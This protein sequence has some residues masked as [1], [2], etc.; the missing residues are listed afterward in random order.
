M[1]KNGEKENCPS[2][3]YFEE[4][5]SYFLFGTGQRRCVCVRSELIMLFFVKPLKH[6]FEI[7]TKQISIWT[8]WSAIKMHYCWTVNW[9]PT[10]MV[11]S[12]FLL[13]VLRRFVLNFFCFQWVWFLFTI[14]TICIYRIP[15][16]P[17]QFTLVATFISSAIWFKLQQ[18]IRR[19][20]E[21]PF[22]FI[23]GAS[24]RALHYR[25]SKY[26]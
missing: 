23:D 11:D 15:F 24:S 18:N 17:Y 8:K 16:Q 25:D 7:C 6:S 21:E 1:C 2:T 14:T 22:I 12:F 13:R 5:N 9:R 19:T 3:F 4:N 20:N 10:R 26:W